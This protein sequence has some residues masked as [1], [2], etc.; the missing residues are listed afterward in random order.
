MGLPGNYL[1]QSSQLA[2]ATAIA[3]AGFSLHFVEAFLEMD[4]NPG[5][6]TDGID[7]C[8]YFAG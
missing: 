1:Y 6:F 2:G 8:C 5:C 7:D 4:Q 3:A